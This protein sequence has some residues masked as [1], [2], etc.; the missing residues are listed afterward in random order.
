MQSSSLKNHLL[1]AMPS[2]QDQ[3]FA[4][5][6]TYLCE[7]NANGAMGIVIN[8][9]TTLKLTDVFTQM[10]ITVT[11]PNSANTPIFAGGPVEEGRGFILH[12]QEGTWNST[13]RVTDEMSITSSRDI[14]EAIA[15]GEGPTK[16]LMAL[17]YAGWE[18]GKLEQEILDNAWLLCPTHEDILFTLAPEKRWQAAASMIGVDLNLLSRESGH[19]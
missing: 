19:A 9:P 16:K 10:D 18:T 14:V 2:L 13:L 5:T 11:N 6:V 1:V 12:K 8:R 7:H 3:R 4:R 15:Q 17:G